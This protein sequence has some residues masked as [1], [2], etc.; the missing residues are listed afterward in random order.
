MI[1]SAWIRVHPRLISQPSGHYQLPIPTT[2]SV[3]NTPSTQSTLARSIT[4][5]FFVLIFY[6]L[7]FATFFSPVIFFNH[8]LAPA[9]G[10]IQ[11]VPNFYS[12]KVLWDKLILSGFPMTADPS[13]MTW[14]PLS[15]IFS[16]LPDAWNIFVLS[17]YVLMSSFTYGYVYT[18]TRCRRAATVSGIVYGMGGFMMAHLGHT[19]IIH[20]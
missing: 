8:L 13:V 1:E 15:L 14:Y 4:H 18:L 17:A 20:S 7:L 19:T 9:D 3:S 11:S 2:D 5:C 12:N 16:Q 10:I 6:S